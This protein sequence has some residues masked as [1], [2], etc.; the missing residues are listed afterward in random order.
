MAKLKIKNQSKLD[1][2]IYSW[3]KLPYAITIFFAMIFVVLLSFGAV[4]FFYNTF[5][6]YYIREE[7]EKRLDNAIASCRNLESVFHDNLDIGEKATD[8]EIV[9][10]VL[11]TIISSADVSSDANIV[12]FKNEPDGIDIL[13]PSTSYSVSANTNASKIVEAVKTENPIAQSNVTYSLELDGQSYYYRVID[14]DYNLNDG[15]KFTLPNH[16]ICV[17]VNSQ[18]YYSF[19]TSFNYAMWQIIMI[20]II[21][22][23]IISIVISMPLILSTLKLSR[24]SKRISEGNYE[25]LKGRLVSRE[26]YDLG[27]TMN[28]MAAKLEEADREQQTFFQNASHELRTPLQ[29]IQG[30]AEGLKY[31]VFDEEGKKQAVDIIINESSRLTGMV[32]N[33]LSIS[34]M[35]MSSKGN[36]RVKKNNLSSKILCELVVENIRGNVLHANKELILDL[37]KKAV[38]LNANS[39]DLL[40]MFENLFSNCLRYCKNNVTLK[41]RVEDNQAVYYV[42]DDG[43]GISDEVMPHL[44]SRFAKGSDGKHG[45]GL[46][47]CKAIADEH[48]GSIKGYNR[49]E[50]GACFEVRLPAKE[51]NNTIG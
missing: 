25:R 16:H 10:V 9:D 45:I 4:T 30:Y 13:W 11:H 34:K 31:D 36:Y 44:F 48:N 43:D 3:T 27:D 24:F 50:G 28:N 37:D 1:K 29:S 40:R 2:G 6:S 46:A 41:Y 35:D 49:P 22:A 26:M 8:D 42:M 23:A 15:S 33:L 18:Y 19:M 47:L 7:C 20:A 38:T 21:A 14:I 17:F 12:L 51:S 5:F 39:G 32:E